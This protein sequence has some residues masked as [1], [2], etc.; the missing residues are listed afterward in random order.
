[1]LGAVLVGLQIILLPLP[2]DPTIEHHQPPIDAAHDAFDFGTGNTYLSKELKIVYDNL[3]NLATVGNLAACEKR[4]IEPYVAMGR[5]PHH[6]SWQQR[7]APLPGPPPEE[8]S[9]QDKM[10]YKRRHGAGQSALWRT[11]MHGRTGDRHY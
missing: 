2:T 8:A 3:C 4:G 7:F 1:M 6:P 5:D 9:A 10:A 11:Q